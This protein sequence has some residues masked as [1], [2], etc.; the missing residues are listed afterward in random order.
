MKYW[1]GLKL[2]GKEFGDLDAAVDGR[3]SRNV[4]ADDNGE[5]GTSRGAKRRYWM[6]KPTSE[7]ESAALT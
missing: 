1:G 5:T 2:N 4:N 7:S 6:E 3:I